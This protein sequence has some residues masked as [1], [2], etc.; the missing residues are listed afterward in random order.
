LKMTYLITSDMIGHQDVELGKKLMN[1]FC[2]TLVEADNLPT[3]LLFMERGVHLL[4]DGFLAVDALK[5]LEDKGIIL[6]ACGTCLDYYGLRDHLVTGQV[7]SMTE[8]LKVM[9]ETDKVIKL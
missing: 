6:L 2:R 1:S 4:T 5:Y 8:I 3:H 7:S 9:H